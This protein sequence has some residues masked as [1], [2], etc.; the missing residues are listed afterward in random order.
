[1]I[2]QHTCACHAHLHAPR[3]QQKHATHPTQHTCARTHKARAHTYIH[4]AHAQTQARH[5][6]AELEN[7]TRKTAKR[8]MHT[9]QMQTVAR[10]TTNKHAKQQHACMQANAQRVCKLLP[11]VVVVVRHYSDWWCH[12][13]IQNNGATPFF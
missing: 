5:E 3:K 2:N 6:M 12:T 8:K 7:C 4:N 13:I 11:V 10:R 9:I 1:M